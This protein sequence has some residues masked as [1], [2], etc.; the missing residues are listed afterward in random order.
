M[1]AIRR[2]EKR[3]DPALV[4]ELAGFGVA[5]IADSMGRFGAMKPYIK[6]LA[7]GQRMAGPALTVQAYRSDN[8][9]IHV[10]LE[11]A[12]AGDV[13]VVDAGGVENAGGWGGLMGT[14]AKIKGLGGIVTDGAVRDREE[15][16]ELGVPV[17]SRS[18]SPLGCFKNDLGSVGVRIACGG[19]PV[20]PGDVVVG[21]GDGVAVVPLGQAEAVLE[22]CRKTQAKE[23]AIRAG[24]AEGR[25]LFSLLGL[26]KQLAAM[27]VELPD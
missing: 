18:V 10:A 27:G 8:L 20:G 14:M 12:E 1:N 23:D 7:P 15:L 11:L 19:V 5:M 3:P 17:Y 4:R 24:M 16:A 6:P 2:L 21:D 13:L 25:T 22:A 26:D 9:M